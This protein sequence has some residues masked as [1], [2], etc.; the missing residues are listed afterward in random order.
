MKLAVIGGGPAGLAAALEGATQGLQVVLFERYRIGQKIACAEVLIDILG[1]V[2]PLAEGVRCKLD[3]MFFH[4]SDIYEFP[5]V[6]LSL[7]SLDRQAWQLSLARKVSSLGVE[8]REGEKIAVGSLPLLQKQYDY[9]IDAGGFASPTVTR[10]GLRD[11]LVRGAAKA[12]QYTLWGDFSSL[13]PNIWIELGRKFC[14][15]FWIF[16][17][18]SPKNWH[19]A[20]VGICL[21]PGSGQDTICLKKELLQFLERKG[22]SS[23]KVEKTCGGLIFNSWPEEL[24]FDNIILA[25]DAAGLASPLHGGGIDTAFYSGCLAARCV[26]GGEVSLYREKITA[27]LGPR[28]KAERDLASTWHKIGY[29]GL[30]SILKILAGKIKEVSPASLLKYYRSLA[31]CRASLFYFVQLL[32]GSNNYLLAAFARKQR[33]GKKAEAGV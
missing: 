2:P 31:G 28:L 15:Y 24:V 21:F 29:E 3:K 19:K 9:V 22:M 20:N 30:D 26:A 14:G 25:G 8:I 17:A 18:G 1:I 23:L 7:F 27:V 32:F 33:N 12:L 6:A 5:A 10:Y 4:G 16:P 13:G 11:R